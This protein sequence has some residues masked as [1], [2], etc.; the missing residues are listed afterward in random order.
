LIKSLEE[1]PKYRL[2]TLYL[3]GVKWSFWKKGLFWEGILT[4]MKK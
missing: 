1:M 3:K 2:Y 4:L